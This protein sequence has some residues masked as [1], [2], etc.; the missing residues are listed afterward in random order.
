MLP[1]SG[2]CRM[3]WTI[4]LCFFQKCSFP[5]FWIKIPSSFS[6]SQC[7]G[8]PLPRSWQMWEKC[9]KF[10]RW[11]STPNF[12][13]TILK[14]HIR[15]QTLFDGCPS[16]FMI[17]IDLFIPCVISCYPTCSGKCFVFQSRSSKVLEQ[18]IVFPP[19]LH[20][21]SNNDWSLHYRGC[22]ELSTSSEDSLSGDE[23]CSDTVLTDALQ[24]LL[25]G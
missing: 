13:V 17:L 18:F 15:Y 4:E 14:F 9:G 16:L 6:P 12:E 11:K 7:R 1:S 2:E 21:F 10:E 22:R 5:R 20:M 8:K 19:R 24:V 23:P 25:M 3:L